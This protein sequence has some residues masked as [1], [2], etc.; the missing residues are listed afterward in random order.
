MGGQRYQHFEDVFKKS[1]RNLERPQD[2]LQKRFQDIF[3]ASPRHF[4]DVFKASC[5]DV[6]KMFSR[7]I[8]KLI[9][10]VSAS[11]RRIQYVSEKYFKDGNLE[12][13]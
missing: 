9:A 5:K 7:R 2:V 8:I 13:D 1:W 10:F 11:L 4:E 3:K 12:R 6:F